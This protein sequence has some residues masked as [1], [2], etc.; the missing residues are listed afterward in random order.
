ML[1]RWTCAGPG[2]AGIMVEGEIE[3]IKKV[4]V[5]LMENDRHV[6]GGFVRPSLR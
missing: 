5:D 1:G 6:L 4:F 3:L 2:R